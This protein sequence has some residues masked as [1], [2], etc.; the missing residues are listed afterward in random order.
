MPMYMYMWI[1]YTPCTELDMRSEEC[2]SNP[3]IRRPDL[4]ARCLG[5]ALESCNRR[6]LQRVWC[7]NEGGSVERGDDASTALAACPQS[8]PESAPST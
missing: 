4:S 8:A 7:L 2:V 6:V 3:Y 1:A 5:T